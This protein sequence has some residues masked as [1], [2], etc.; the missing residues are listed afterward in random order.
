MI[1]PSVIVTNDDEEKKKKS[2]GE[3]VK[4]KERRTNPLTT[5]IVHRSFSLSPSP[6]SKEENSHNRRHHRQVKKVNVDELNSIPTSRR[7]TFNENI[8]PT[9]KSNGMNNFNESMTDLSFSFSFKQKKTVSHISWLGDQLTQPMALHTFLM[10]TTS[11][12][13]EKLPKKCPTSNGLLN[14]INPSTQRKSKRLSADIDSLANIDIDKVTIN[15]Q[16][17]SQLTID[18]NSSNT[19]KCIEKVIMLTC[20]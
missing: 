2:D 4:E 19:G 5:H 10:K 9:K 17:D 13:S 14:F 3:T 12:N 15:C 11:F 18:N 1:Q 16:K 7:V 20:I 8:S 6:L